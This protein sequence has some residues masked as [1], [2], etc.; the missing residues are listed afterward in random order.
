MSMLIK[1]TCFRR[2]CHP[3]ALLFVLA[4]IPLVAQGVMGR[5]KKQTFAQSS[6]SF[7]D[8]APDP[9]S[10]AGTRPPL[11]KGLAP[12]MSETLCADSRST[13]LTETVVE[14]QILIKRVVS[15]QTVDGKINTSIKESGVISKTARLILFVK[16]LYSDA[17]DTGKPI[18]IVFT[19]LND[20][21]LANAELTYTLGR[22]IEVFHPAPIPSE[23][24]VYAQAKF[25]PMLQSAK[26][27]QDKPEDYTP[28]Q[29]INK[30]RYSIYSN[31][32]GIHPLKGNYHCLVWSYLEFDAVAPILLVHGTN[33]SHTTWN[34]PSSENIQN[35][36]FFSFVPSAFG[37]SAYP[38]AWFYRID[39]DESS[40]RNLWHGG[41]NTID[42][43]GK[44]L[45]EFIK[46]VL[47]ALGSKKCHVIAHSKGGSDSRSMLNSKQKRNDFVSVLETDPE[48]LKNKYQ[49]LS[50]FTI[51][52][53]HLGTPLSDMAYSIAP[54]LEYVRDGKVK[55]DDPDISAMIGSVALAAS[56]HVG[57][58]R[59]AVDDQRTDERR[60][61]YLT[62]QTLEKT[63]GHFYS[64]VGDADLNCNGIMDDGEKTT[65][66]PW[67][68]CVTYADA[69]HIYRILGK[70]RQIKIQS[71]IEDGSFSV[72]CLEL[73]PQDIDP[74]TT[75]LE[76][77]D[78][79]TPF[80]SGIGPKAIPF[81]VPH[82]PFV[83]KF[84]HSAVPQVAGLEYSQVLTPGNHSILKDLTTAT[85]ILYRIKNDYP[86]VEF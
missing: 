12:V 32:D 73:T 3:A 33:A 35:R 16:F 58:T 68:T 43:S 31:P 24:L 52:T 47:N 8:P 70:A 20:H 37:P 64:I 62:D 75:T 40:W 4:S 26:D 81:Q 66:F 84:G 41:N 82:S 74:S 22:G 44:E 6:P 11:P 67:T 14:D 17:E 18:K 15:Y 23:H 80:W 7:A 21:D 25:D 85:A 49:V 10:L 56:L 46:V 72:P 50:L 53:P 28:T 34:E 5:P 30:L 2:I 60:D 79:V 83:V 1:P 48:L 45:G 59:G 71:S 78:L 77:N 86:L 76:P 55:S 27:I 57:P 38:G 36:T 63:A 29:G 51:G 19:K 65:L 9:L 61:E 42:E 69:N 54:N 13:L 39:L